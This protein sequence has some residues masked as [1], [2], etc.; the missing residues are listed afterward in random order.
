VNFLQILIL[1]LVQGAAELLPVSSS[2]HVIIAEKLMGLD[3]SSPEMTFVLVMLHT[4]TMFAVIAYFWKAWKEHYFSSVVKF[5]VIALNVIIATVVT[6][7]IGIALQLIIE[8]IFLKGAEKAEVELLFSQLPLIAAALLAVG[9]LI[10]YSG[11]REEQTQRARDVDSRKACWIGAIQGLSLPFRGFSRSGSTIST[12]LLLGVGRRRMEEFSFALA[13]VLTPPVIARELLRLVKANSE[14]AHPFHVMQLV[15]PGLLG[16]LCSFC[17]GLLALSL[18]SRWLESGR[19]KLF[20]YYCLA[21]AV[22]VF[23]L[24]KAGF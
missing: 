5:K 6:G 4:G 22:V 14:V 3:P 23:V 24:S 18:L 11:L 2:A 9:V 7:V 20:G 15:L 16:M 21:A 13:V 10:I 12:G 8:K 1:G 17:A 19:W